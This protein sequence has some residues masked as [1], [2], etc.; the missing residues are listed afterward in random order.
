MQ[1]WQGLMNMAN[2]ERSMQQEINLRLNKK[3]YQQL[4]RFGMMNCIL[5]ACQGIISTNQHK[6]PNL[7]SQL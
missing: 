7:L 1:D 4:A 2:T 3:V 6:D 5:L